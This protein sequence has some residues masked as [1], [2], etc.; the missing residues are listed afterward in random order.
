MKNVLF[1]IMLILGL[2]TA[3]TAAVKVE[4]P[5]SCTHCG[6][7]RTTFAHS[8]MVITYADGS[9]AGTC[10][11]ACIATDL[12][13]TK[14]KPIKSVSVADYNSKSLIDAKTAN[15][16]IGGKKQGIMT[17]VAKWA[18][19]DKKSAA[20]FIKQHGG[21]LTTFE[22]VLKE[23]EKEVAANSQESKGSM[24]KGH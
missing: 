10:S 14:G 15:W 24:H 21:K 9:S 1:A 7:N 11:I 19:A 20:A 4:P 17:P 23:A 16:V 3:A 8:R 2:V 13:Q 12:Q 5:D 6:M 18:F 22:V